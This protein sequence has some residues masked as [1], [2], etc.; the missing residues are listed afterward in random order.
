MRVLAILW[1][2]LTI[3][4]LYKVISEYA[5]QVVA[6]FTRRY[7]GIVSALEMEKRNELVCF[8]FHLGLQKGH[9]FGTSCKSHNYCGF[10]AAAAYLT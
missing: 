9:S 5:F 7:A 4:S 3:F 6:A 1:R 2:D 8:Y 10:T